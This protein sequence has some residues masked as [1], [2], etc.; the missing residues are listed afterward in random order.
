MSLP[1]SPCKRRA[2]ARLKRV[3]SGP[4]RLRIRGHAHQNSFDTGR[5]V[6]VEV[7]ANG[8]TLG[9]SQLERTGLFIF[10]AD[11]PDAE[12]YLVEV[13]ASPEWTAPPDDRVL[14]VSLSRLRLVPR[15]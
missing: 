11:L 12:E 10:E 3:R 13:S 4:Q 14:T 1:V 6:T 7:R 15:D 5:K 9:E 8:E 2:S